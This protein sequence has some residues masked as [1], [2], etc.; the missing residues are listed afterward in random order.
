MEITMLG[1]PLNFQF[2]T[3]ASCNQCTACLI[4]CIVGRIS[5]NLVFNKSSVTVTVTVR[6]CGN[7]MICAKWAI[8]WFK[9]AFSLSDDHHTGK[10]PLHTIY[11]YIYTYIY[12]QSL[13]MVWGATR[14]TLPDTRKRRALGTA[15]EFQPGGS[16]TCIPCDILVLLIFLCVFMRM[17][18]GC[19]IYICVL[20]LKIIC[21]YVMYVCEYA[22]VLSGFHC[23]LLS[24]LPCA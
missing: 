23:K 3:L 16:F 10:G 6:A 17:C 12:V 13:P 4:R 8:N 15:L 18:I 7:E 21:M 1:K 9:T 2:Q 24:D 20:F 22:C 11:I 14:L 19:T 5:S